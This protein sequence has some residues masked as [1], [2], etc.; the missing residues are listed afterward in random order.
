MRTVDAMAEDLRRSAASVTASHDTRFERGDE[1]PLGNRGR[2]TRRA[3]LKAAGEVFTETGWSGASMAAISERAGVAVGTVYQYFRGKEEI[4]SATVGEWT[5][6]SLRQIRTWDPHDGIDGLAAIIGQY[7]EMYART[8]RFQ[9]VWE[10]V[11][12][13]EP[14]LA[15]LRADLTDL[16]VQVFAEA[17][18]TGATIGLLDPGPDPVETARAVTSMIDRYCLQVFVRRSRP[19]ARSRA[20]RLLTDLALAALHAQPAPAPTER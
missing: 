18:E 1:R 19:A 5:L 16:F 11:S 4:I 14:A 17:F 2:R 9:R 15:D 13:V 10:E 20:A 8:A 12:L 7:V 6:W 3:I